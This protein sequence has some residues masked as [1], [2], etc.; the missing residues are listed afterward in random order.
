LQCIPQVIEHEHYQGNSYRQQQLVW[1]SIDM[2]TTPSIK[3][4]ALN[5]FKAVDTALGHSKYYEEWSNKSRLSVDAHLNGMA[6]AASSH[7]LGL[8]HIDELQFLLKYSKSANTPNLQNIEALFN[9]IGIPIIMSCTTHGLQVFLPDCNARDTLQ[10]DMTTVRRMLSDRLFHFESVKFGS[11]HF[12]DLFNALFPDD[13]SHPAIIFD[14]AFKEKFYTH[15]CGLPAVMTRLAQLFYEVLLQLV[16]NTEK[17]LPTAMAI[18]NSVFKDQFSLIEPALKLL[19][20]GQPDLYEAKLLSSDSGKRAFS[21]AEH[22]A[23]PRKSKKAPKAILKEGMYDK[24]AKDPA[25][26]SNKPD[27]SFGEQL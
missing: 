3:A 18:L 12:T 13:L 5:F 23:M 6:L 22:A 14:E 7:E 24:H 26:S 17:K 20:A 16:S 15:S 1:I 4:L 11:L 9:K 19:R 10:F 8:V 21:N 2:P 27:G 25:P